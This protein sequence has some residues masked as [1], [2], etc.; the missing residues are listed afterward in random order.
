MWRRLEDTL[1]T[2]CV[3]MRGRSHGTNGLSILLRVLN[4][5][6]ATDEWQHIGDL[7]YSRT[8][9]IT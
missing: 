2:D 5:S 1:I 3:I 7:M 9:C 6:T 4:Y 8:A